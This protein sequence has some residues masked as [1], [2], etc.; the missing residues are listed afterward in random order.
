MGDTLKLQTIKTS[1]IQ[2]IGTFFEKYADDIQAAYM[3]GGRNVKLGFSCQ[4]AMTDK[5]KIGHK[6]E[7]NFVKIRVKDSVFHAYDPDQI[8]FD[9][10]EDGRG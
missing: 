8:L 5:G 1:T 7:V 10:E 3:D 6:T 2:S 9:F 4:I